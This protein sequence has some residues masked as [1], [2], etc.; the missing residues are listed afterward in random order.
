MGT[1]TLAVRRVAGVIQA[2]SVA[3]ADDGPALIVPVVPVGV[4]ESAGAVAPVVVDTRTLARIGT[5][6]VTI[7]V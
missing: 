4:D 2:K 3:P 7:T 1:R 6:L 5:A